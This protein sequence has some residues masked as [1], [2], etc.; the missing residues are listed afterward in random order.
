MAWFCAILFGVGVLFLIVLAILEKIG[1]K[2]IDEK[3]ATAINDRFLEGLTR[4]PRYFFLIPA[5]DGFFLLPLLYIGLNPIS[6]A[7]AAAVFAAA[8]Y[9]VFPWRY[10]LPKGIAYFFVAIFVLPRGIWSVVVA[11]LLVD[12]AMFGLILL[13]KVEGKPT[14][15]RLL[16][17]LKTR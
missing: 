3:E 8:H 9:P 14:L 17:A 5:E 4:N 1:L 12:T 2:P 15:R 13:T 7:I 10:C 6:A 11:H 16:R